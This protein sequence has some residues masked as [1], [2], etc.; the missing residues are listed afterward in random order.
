MTGDHHHAGPTGATSLGCPYCC[1]YE[2]ERL[3]LASVH[4]DSCRCR[5]CGAGW[6]EQLGTGEFR[7]RSDRQSTLIPP[8]A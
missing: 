4:L 5:A 6:E 2:V 3:Y 7:G 8:S 1:S